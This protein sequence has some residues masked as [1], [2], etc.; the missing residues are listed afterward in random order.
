[1]NRTTRLLLLLITVVSVALALGAL[2]WRW[3]EAGDVMAIL[4][5]KRGPFLLAA[6]AVMAGVLV[7]ATKAANPKPSR[8]ETFFVGLTLV[9]NFLLILALQTR[10]ALVYLEAAAPDGVFV[11]RLAV[12]VFGLAMAVRGN[13]LAKAPSPEDD[14]HGEWA[15]ATRRT[16]MILVGLGLVLTAGAVTLPMTGLLA[17]LGVAFVVILL[18]THVQ[19]RVRKG[20]LSA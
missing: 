5:S 6:P 17:L 19:R 15:R 10:M 13:F 1:M 4:A 3:R 14:V 7:L 12:A 20:L 18:L 2:G 16:A 8:Y 11:M 9:T